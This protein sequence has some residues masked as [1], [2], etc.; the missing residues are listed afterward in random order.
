MAGRS[1]VVVGASAGGVES[2]RAVVRGLPPDL[3]A[4]VLVVLHTTP[5]GSSVLASIL[6]RAGPL[7]ATTATD[8][9]ELLP[10]HIYV[11]PPD[12]HLTVLH[13]R[14]CLSRGPQEN[15]HRPAIDPLFRSAVR[16]AGSAVVGVVLSGMLDDGAAGLAAIARH[17][18]ATAVQSPDDALYPSMCKAALDAVPGAVTASADKLGPLIGELVAQEPDT[19]PAPDDPILTQETAIAELDMNALNDPDRPGDPA[20]LGCP[21]C[22]GALF[23]VQEGDFL[24]YRCRVGHA[25]SPASLL[26][27]QNAAVEGALWMALRTMEDKARCTGGWPNRPVTAARRS[28]RRRICGRR[29]TWARPPD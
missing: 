18:G 10:G 23:A 29:R 13:D 15:G 22:S 14:C 4:A 21:D 7:P 9:A 3:P 2:L 12:H 24:R 28:S 5:G 20:G 16:S 19:D 1:L 27:R 11:A 17:A 25:W 6:D 8:G 26:E